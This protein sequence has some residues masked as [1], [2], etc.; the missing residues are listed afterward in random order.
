MVLRLVLV[1]IVAGLGVTPPAESELSGWTRS[2]Q[3]W[4]D[5]QLVEW[6]ARGLLNEEERAFDSAA[7]APAANETTTKVPARDA[8]EDALADLDFETLVDA[9][10]DEFAG[11][12][13]A[14]EPARIDEKKSAEA[15]AVAFD[16]VVDEMVADF[17]KVEVADKAT[18]AAPIVD[19]ADA[20]DLELAET[21]DLVTRAIDAAPS[22]AETV[23]QG[24]DY[25][26]LEV[27]EDLYPGEAYVLNRDAEG[28][29][30][31]A[32]IGGIDAVGGVTTGNQINQAVRLT[33]DA[34]YAWLNLL[35]SPAI[36]TISR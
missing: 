24:T 11:E 34:V 18:P 19:E 23:M 15:E 29:G 9:T 25:Q 31:S 5:A 10:A 27:G 8:E 12:P 17:S 26:P 22:K 14:D 35:Q 6:N 13:A 4:L 7:E 3:T 33:R 21:L 30:A 36:V 2:V 32:P 1:G 28:L 20:L 16:A